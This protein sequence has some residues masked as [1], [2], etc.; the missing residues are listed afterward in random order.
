MPLAALAAS[1][2][3]LAAA[4]AADAPAASGLPADDYGLMA[5]CYG[6]LSGHVDLYDKVLPEVTR[7]ETAFPEP[8]VPVDKAMASY[9][10]QNARGKQLL[11]Q[12]ARALDRLEAKS[13]VDKAERQEAVARGRQ[14]WAGAETADPR[15]LAQLWMSWGL[16]GRCDAAAKKFGGGNGGR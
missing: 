9:K 7:I 6:A 1:L 4:P 2:A 11:V 3:L 16:P 12:Y 10:T 14:T 13:K 8:N 5:W 15:Q